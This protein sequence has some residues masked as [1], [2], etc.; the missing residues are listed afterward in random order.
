[1]DVQEMLKNVLLA[2]VGAVALTAEKGNDLLKT[3]VEKGE[4]TVEQ[5]KALN[6]ELKRKAEEKK[7]PEK[8]DVTSLLDG[9][10]DED[11]AKLKEAIAKKE[12]K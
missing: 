11:L 2:Q 1:M 12:E 8:K 10:S 6:E 3:L 9:L 4:I 7:E 5:G